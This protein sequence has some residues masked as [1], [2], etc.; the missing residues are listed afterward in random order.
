MGCGLSVPRFRLWERGERPVRTFVEGSVVVAYVSTCED[1]E[2]GDIF[3]E[4]AMVVLPHEELTIMPDCA[5]LS[6]SQATD[7]GQGTT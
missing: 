3:A 5:S 7:P 4:P 2:Y 1:G 6:M